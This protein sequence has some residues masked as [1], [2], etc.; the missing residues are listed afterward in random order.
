MDRLALDLRQALRLVARSPL[1]ALAVVATLGLGIGANTAMFTVLDQVLLR[2]LPVRSPGEL[3]VLDSPGPDTGSS[4]ASSDFSTLFSYPLYRDLRDGTRDA[5]FLLARFRTRVNLAAEGEPARV[6]AEI[7]SGNYFEVLGVGSS[8][9]R[10]LAPGDDGERLARPV[11][12]LSHAFWARRFGGDPAVVGKALRLNGH[13]FTVVGVAARGFRGVEVGW[14]P[15]VFVPM[16]M[17]AWITPTWDG[18]DSRRWMWLN[19]MGRL[20]PGVDASNAAAAAGLVY[21]RLREAEAAEMP[22]RTGDF[23]QRFVSRPLLLEPG[24]RGRGDLRSQFGTELVVLMGMVGLVLLV[25]CANVANLLG[26]RALSRQREIA[27]RLALGATRKRLVGQ[28]LAEGLVLAVLGGAVG[29]VTSYWATGALLGALPLG[30]RSNGFTAAP[31][32][33]VLAFT[34]GVSLLSS[35]FFG[36][37]PALQASRASLV[38]ALR[39]EAGSLAGAKGALRLRRGLVAAEVA[40]SFL[41]LV[42]AGLFAHSLRNLRH[43]DPGFDPRPLLAFSVEPARAGYSAE[44]TQHLVGRLR[45]EL[46]ALPGVLSATA[47]ENGVLTNS[48]SSFSIAVQ[49]YTP[50]P[51]ERVSAQM[52]FVASGF[53]DTLQ[54]PVL[55]GRAIDARD[56]AGAP[57]VAVV[58]ESLARRY[59]GP[60]DPVGRRF[61]FGRHG[62]PDEI[63]VV[64]VVRDGRHASL[65]DGVPLMAY[66]PHAQYTDSTGGATFYLR[67][68]G[69]PAALGGAAR[70]AVR[71]VDPALPVNDVATMAAVVDESLLLDRLSSGLS[72]VFGLVATVLAAIGLYAVTSFT[73]AR[74]TREIGLRMALGADVRSVLGLVLRDVMSTAAVGIALGLPLAVALGRLFESRLVGLRASDPGTLSAATLALLL[75]V[76]L[77]GYLPARRATRVDPMVA[78]RVE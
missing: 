46:A 18:M 45:D 14:S 77:A 69:D 64:G 30:S 7:V 62:H 5:L 43:L 1:F 41:L 55:R 57:R 3:V 42:G 19:A 38:Q 29:L 66:L 22:E 59:F 8:A 73:V 34:L 76:L 40:L 48:V 2:P 17:K 27:V 53:F 6:E 4:E 65:R 78:L 49:G 44:E 51:D 52:N 37:A 35:L 75:V 71:R 67:A 50:G 63:E 56:G 32:A 25:A 21:R 15:D 58:N 39:D 72:A 9:G 68:A 61:G 13:P 24:G 33:R 28:L 16:A 11:A 20:A 60:G 70:E 10:V 36:L 23:K 74:R 26:A 54:V 31:D 47:A 12:V